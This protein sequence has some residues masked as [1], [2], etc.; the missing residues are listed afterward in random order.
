MSSDRAIRSYEN[1]SGKEGCKVFYRAD[2][3]K[4]RELFSRVLP[5]VEIGGQPFAL[6]DLSMSGI[7]VYG[8]RRLDWPGEPGQEVRVECHLEEISLYHGTAR[9]V[10]VES[11][12]FGP[13]VALQ[14]TDGYLDIPAI[15]GQHREVA[16]RR[17]LE[18]ERAATA[19]IEPDYRRLCG[20]VVHLLRYARRSLEG[21]DGAESEEMLRI[22]EEVMLPEW[23][24]LWHAANDIVA[25]YL[26]DPDVLIAAKRFTELVVT[27]E[28]LD[29]P[30][31]RRSYEKPL[32]YPGDYEI[33]NYVY[34]W[35]H[36][37]E[38]AYARLVHRLG[39][40]VVECIATRMEAVKKVIATALA[41][42]A[43]ADVVRIAS[44]G[45]GPAQEVVAYLKL[46]ALPAKV[47]FTLI[48][49]DHAALSQAYERTY[50][51][52]V[53]FAGQ[54]SV[55]CL[56]ASFIQLMKAG[57]LFRKMP[58]QDLIYSVGLTDYLSDRRAR[59]LIG[60]L[61]DQLAPGGR[62]LVANLS[63]SPKG[64]LWP[65]EFVS[66][67]TL[68]YRTEDE[69]RALADGV[70]SA[71]KIDMSKDSTGNVYLMSIGK[72]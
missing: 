40:E 28:L 23:R 32:G 12:P 6:H 62:L 2:R 48:D 5:R 4:V 20:D 49:Q 26:D 11:T 60:A 29:G 38:S 45:A 72:P 16:L 58:P 18:E 44:L 9:V 64:T 56:E 22:C 71:A 61:Y 52:V 33:M 34:R 65:A 47:D 41:E 24:T 1:L 59:A 57:Q 7:A 8:D 13:K 39:L 35:R 67:W 30:I 31:W 21:I 17:A 42:H 27:P 37:G 46:D 14:L 66:D 3:Y 68:V 51:D 36:E 69:F 70:T 43:G 25:P 54:V 19:L 55:H 10:R 15:A 63:D 50:P 53:R